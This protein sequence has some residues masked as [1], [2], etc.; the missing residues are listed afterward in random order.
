M[1]PLGNWGLFVFLTSMYFALHTVTLDEAVCLVA[2][3][4]CDYAFRFRDEPSRKLGALCFS[5]FD[6][7]CA[8]HG[9]VG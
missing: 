1:S 7:F 9:D 8:A 6:V 4:G 2:T 3:V 5:D